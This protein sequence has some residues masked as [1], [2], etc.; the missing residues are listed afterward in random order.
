MCFKSVF[1]EEE[2]R[3]CLEV[4]MRIKEDIDFILDI[5]KKIVIIWKGDRE[6]VFLGVR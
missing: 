4:I 1:V 6:V 2:K 5:E 3:N